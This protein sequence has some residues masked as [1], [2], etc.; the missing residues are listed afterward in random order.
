MSPSE[1]GETEPEDNKAL[2]V[3]AGLH[4]ID[5]IAF[6]LDF[7]CGGGDLNPYAF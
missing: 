1:T 5:F 6:F 7:W 3:V 4:F 2:Q